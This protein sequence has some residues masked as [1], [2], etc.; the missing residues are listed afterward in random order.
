MLPCAPVSGSAP[1]SSPRRICPCF[2]PARS[3]RL[4]SFCRWGL[5]VSRKPTA[6]RLKA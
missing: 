6:G 3:R 2:S 5:T 1:Y 4:K